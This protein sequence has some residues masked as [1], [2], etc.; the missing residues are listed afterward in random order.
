MVFPP[1]RMGWA[2]RL[3]LR[4]R[5][6]ALPIYNFGPDSQVAPRQARDGSGPEASAFVLR[7]KVS[8]K[9]ASGRHC[10]ECRRLTD[11]YLEAVRHHAG[12]M[13]EEREMLRGTVDDREWKLSQAER[14]VNEARQRFLSHRAIHSDSDTVTVA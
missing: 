9:M 12:L 10:E 11:L 7:G 14:S 4:E 5:R 3:G 1:P 13:D 6:R 8:V 2:A